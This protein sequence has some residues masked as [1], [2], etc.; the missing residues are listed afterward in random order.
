MFVDHRNHYIDYD[1]H[2][3]IGLYG[4]ALC[5]YG[6]IRSLK[7]F[8]PLELSWGHGSPSEILWIVS[9]VKEV[10]VGNSH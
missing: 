1:K 8:N 7:D 9:F 5:T 3:V 2:L 10:R 4:R 6:F